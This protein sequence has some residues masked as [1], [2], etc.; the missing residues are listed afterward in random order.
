MAERISFSAGQD[1]CAWLDSLGGYRNP[2]K[3]AALKGA[4]AH[5]VAVGPVHAGVIE[6]GHFRFQCMGEDV[7]NLQIFLGYQH[8][9]V[10]DA[11]VSAD[12]N[13]ARQTALAETC[14]GDT[15]AAAATAFAEL[16]ECAFPSLYPAPNGESLRIRN[17]LVELERVAN[18]VGDLGA[19]AGDVA[20]LQTASFCGRIRGEYLNMTA[21]LCGNRFGR[22]AIIPGGI[23]ISPS[24]S[25]YAQIKEWIARVKPELDRALALMF[26]EHSA[27]DR[28]DGTGKVSKEIARSIPLVGVARRASEEFNGDVMA[29]ALVRRIEINEAHEKIGALL[30][31]SHSF[32]PLS[33]SAADKPDSRDF[34]CVKAETP[35]WRGPLIHAAAFSPEGKMLRYKIVDPSAFNWHGLAWALRGEQI[36]NFPICNKSFNLSYC[37]TDR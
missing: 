28:F 20:F 14:A 2:E 10:E 4:S 15:S 25:A 17:L 6:P 37:G 34:F 12:G 18:H 9:G 36:S 8:R 21:L 33:P 26:D 19:L 31:N 7:Y 11:I 22:N 29:R 30:D 16:M 23:R 27:C 5:E 13:P 32:A 1:A 35:A 3:V 24:D